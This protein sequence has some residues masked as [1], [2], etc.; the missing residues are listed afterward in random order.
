M[1]EYYF[2]GCLSGILIVLLS[3]RNNSFS[4][5][6]CA[7]IVTY[8]IYELLRSFFRRLISKNSHSFQADNKHLHSYLFSKFYNR[9]GAEKSKILHSLIILLIPMISCFGQ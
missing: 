3:T 4:P 1:A 2:I 8:P 6:I 9:Y 5:L 7:L